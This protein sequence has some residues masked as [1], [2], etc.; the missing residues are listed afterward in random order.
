VKDWHEH[1]DDF[2]NGTLEGEL[3]IA[4]QKEMESNASLKA[5]VDNYND[6]KLI[7]EGLLE[8]DMM[9][10]LNQLQKSSEE[11]KNQSPDID[12]HS[13]DSESRSQ[14]GEAKSRSSVFRLRTLVSSAAVI[15]VIVFAGWWM[16]TSIADSQRREAVLSQIIR[17]ENEDATKSID[18]VGMNPFEKGKHFYS[19]NKF[20][21]SIEWLELVVSEEK[22]EE[23]LSEGYYWLGHAYIQVWRVDDARESW[24]ESEEEEAKNYLKNIKF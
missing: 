22:D 21:E 8:I 4:F 7:S 15:G 23:L 13:H 19:L 20:E 16:M 18:T 14:L 12:N 1:I 24:G 10:T 9:E 3:L 17:P 2:I 5:A 6:A 11:A